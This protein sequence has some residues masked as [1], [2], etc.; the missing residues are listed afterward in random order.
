MPNFFAELPDPPIGCCASQRRKKSLHLTHA[1]GHLDHAQT[2][3]GLGLHKARLLGASRLEGKP[4][5]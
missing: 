5:K 1:S 3:G 4:R 2:H